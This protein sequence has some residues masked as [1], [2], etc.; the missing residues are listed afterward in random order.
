[1]VTNE[2]RNRWHGH[3]QLVCDS[4]YHPI[5]GTNARQL[6]M[7]LEVFK[8]PGPLRREIF[9]HSSQHQTNTKASED[10]RVADL[11]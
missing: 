1:M 9:P 2:T 3:I 10:T 5:F 6:L 8:V 11:R 7:S 4:W